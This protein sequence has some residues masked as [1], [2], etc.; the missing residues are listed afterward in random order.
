MSENIL[1]ITTES[2]DKE[3]IQSSSLVVI[4]FWGTHCRPCKTIAP[5]IE[6]L[7]K[8]YTGRAKVVKLNVEE[9]PEIASR[10][11]IIGVPTIMF[12]KNGN[13]MD[14]IVGAVPK[15]QLKSKL[16]SLL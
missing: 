6:E 11:R 3:V 15:E 4:D 9:S 1:S 8:E 13:V 10:Y 12:L 14:R 7:A 2:W 5:I 16:E